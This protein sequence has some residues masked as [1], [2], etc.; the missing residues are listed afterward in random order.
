[1][2]AL[3]GLSG[4]LTEN[5]PQVRRNLRN[6]LERRGLAI[7]DQ[8]ITSFSAVNSVRDGCRDGEG[9]EVGR[10]NWQ[11]PYMIHW[12]CRSISRQRIAYSQSWR[13]D[14]G[15]A[16]CNDLAGR[17]VLLP[18]HFFVSCSCLC[19]ISR[20]RRKKKLPHSN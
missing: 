15:G 8:F 11:A 19:Y 5:T 20:G 17:V 16:Y 7:N 1:M 6:D 4:V 10:E 2:D 12:S 18:S 3:N 13:A 9:R 14:G